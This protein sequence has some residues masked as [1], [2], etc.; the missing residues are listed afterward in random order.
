[1]GTKIQNVHLLPTE[2][3]SVEKVLKSLSKIYWN[4]IEKSVEFIIKKSVENL[5]QNLK[6]LNTVSNK[7][8][9]KKWEA[10]FK[11]PF[12]ELIHGKF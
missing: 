1:M 9:H 6:I 10:I 8:I 5:S 12:I 3:Y 11:H 7:K 4:L 2:N